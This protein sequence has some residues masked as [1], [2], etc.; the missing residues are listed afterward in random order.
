M[1]FALAATKVD[2][3][4][5]VRP[6]L[7][8]N[9]FT[10]HGPDEKH[11]MMGLHFDT[12]EGA[13]GKPGVIVPGDSAASRMYQ[14]V[15]N[16]NEAMRMPPVS[17]GHKLTA[18]QI[19]TIKSWIDSGANWETHWSFVVPK[20]AD[21]PVVKDEKWVKT[22]IDRFVLA[23]LEKEGLTPAAEADKATLLRRVTF[24]LTGL[25]PTLEEVKAF[26]EDSSADAYEKVVDRLLASPRYGERMAVPWLDLARYS[27]T[28]GYHIDSAREMWPW[29]DWVI[30]AFNKN[31]PY[32]EF[33]VEQIAGDMLPN[34]TTPQ[35]IATG[36]NRN[37]MINFEGGAIPEEYQNEYIVDRIEATST[38]WLGITLGCARCHDH[39]YDP[40]TQKDFYSLGAFFNGINEQGLDG[41]KGNA[42]PFLQ[43]PSEQQ[44]QMKAALIEAIKKQDEQVGKAQFA[45]EQLQRE[46]PV[47][48]VTT[49][50]TAEFAFDDSL[51]DRLHP[52]VSAKVLNGKV[53]YKDGRAGRAADL[54]E[55][56]QISYGNAGS[57]ATDKPFSVG[58]WLKADGPSG[59]ELLQKYE[60]SAKEGAGYEIG[61]DYCAKN[62][63]NVIVRLRD[64]GA[65]SGIEV[66]SQ[67]GAEL[68][69]WT[70]LLVTYDGSGEAHG[71]QVYVD[72][73]SAPMD[74]VRSRPVHAS[75]DKGELQTGNKEWGTPLK[76]QLEDLRLYD[77]RLYGNEA[78]EL[79]S[80]TPLH[81]VLQVTASKRTDDQKKWLR[82]YFEAEIANPR[83]K[84]SQ[85]DYV[86]LNRG[87]DQLNREIPSTM[88]MSEMDK[89]RD[90]FIL[91]RGDYRNQTDKVTP[92]TPAILPPL[93]ADAP[94]NRLTLARWIVDPQNPLTARV[95]VNHFWQMYFGMG[96]VKTSED[97]GSQ[98][99]P[100]ANQDLLDWMATEFVRT[101]W[102]VKAMQ[103]LIVTSAVYKQSSK[104]TPELLER[105]PE[106]R[107]LAHGPRFRL[108]AEMIR[109]NALAVSGLLNPKI[110]G[111][112]VLPYQPKGLW[113]EM[114]FR[115]RFFGADL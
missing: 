70:H 32:D 78:L 28:H 112:S 37:H 9:C 25:P 7:S 20:R 107:L 86:T 11:R 43:L 57:F 101:K 64:N 63:C 75:F 15:S 115:R 47:A 103:R 22:P 65:D 51:V 29:R 40:L 100:P 5:Q 114:A 1:P 19:E 54:D 50:L 105:D 102:D 93:P 72:G 98:G 27:D 10:C 38:T 110:G 69:E 67:K 8:D 62:N 60:K 94:R 85:R 61:L 66:K 45:W 59:M 106:N 89:P 4:R 99:D 73:K 35:K 56:P 81:T 109:D 68:E 53:A 21:L 41:Y 80:L 12:K 74:V 3:D 108:P 48:D 88:V 52:D 91:K 31:M 84:A 79:G 96:L 76:G 82:D 111:P 113:E 83:E 49:G 71:V 13:F 97:F 44:A 87:L 6:I 26:V 55:E 16:P 14:R 33:T 39:K 2:F 58:F 30:N 90:T 18:A 92:N 34:A 77:R 46:T 23:K 95:A 24:D 104:V 36:F 17:S 42:K